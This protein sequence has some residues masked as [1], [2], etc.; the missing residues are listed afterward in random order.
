[1][2]V[3]A[4]TALAPRSTEAV[5]G[6]GILSDAAGEEAVVE[7]RHAGVLGRHAGN[8][9]GRDRLGRPVADSS[10]QAGAAGR[11]GAYLDAAIKAIRPALA[12]AGFLW[13]SWPKKGSAVATEVNENAV[14]DAAL[15]TGLVDVKVCA[16]DDTWS[17]LK[18]VIRRELR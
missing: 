16:V 12:P 13:A 4:R 1:M 3:I 2:V 6:G 15:L 9:S 8:R 17:G 11:C 14:R 7:G 5:L 10:R 18:L